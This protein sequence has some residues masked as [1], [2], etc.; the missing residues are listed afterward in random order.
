[1]Y[2]WSIFFLIFILKMGIFRSIYF[3]N[4]E[5]Y[6]IFL[7]VYDFLLSEFVSGDVFLYL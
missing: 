3:Q 6:F 1:M 2:F 4:T 7:F 5:L